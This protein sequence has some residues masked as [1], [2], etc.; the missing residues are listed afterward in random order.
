MTVSVPLISTSEVSW[1]GLFTQNV[2]GDKCHLLS[3]LSRHP[4]LPWARNAC[5]SREKGS[6]YLFCCSVVVFFKQS[7]GWWHQ[8]PG[9][10][11]LSRVQSSA[12]CPS[13]STQIL[14]CIVNSCAKHTQT[15]NSLSI[16]RLP[17]RKSLGKQDKQQIEYTAMCLISM[18]ELSDPVRIHF[19]W[20]AMV[21]KGHLQ[22]LSKLTYLRTN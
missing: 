18:G 14:K 2:L 7:F 11:S 10:I 22:I 9:S 19:H 1:K 17:L 6:I 16:N 13:V 4:F 20:Q 15:G 5:P 12:P 8:I 3:R 21:L